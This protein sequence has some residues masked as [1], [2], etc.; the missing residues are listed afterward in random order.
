MKRIR[1]ENN[2]LPHRELILEERYV[3]S[4]WAKV[5]KKGDDECWP[6]KAYRNKQGYGRL[7][8]AASQCVNAHRFSWVLH[9]GSIPTG[10]FIC[11]KCDNPSCV[12]PKHLFVGTRQDN[13]NDM[14][15]KKRGKHF[16]RCEFYGVRYEERCDGPNRKGRWR[17]YICKNEKIIY[18]CRHNS[19]L[20][21]ARNYDRIAY[22]V[23]GERERLNFPEE[24]DIS[25]WT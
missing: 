5:D 22:I 2:C 8:I 1:S 20:E 21:A 10:I 6:W 14:M 9:N 18:I 23:F 16:G 12:N 4:F 15:I 17:S 13:T 7:G 11:H 3:A 25:H 19:V 24:Y